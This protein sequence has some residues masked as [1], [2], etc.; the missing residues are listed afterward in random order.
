MVARRLIWSTLWGS[1]W[2]DLVR[3]GIGQQISAD[4]TGFVELLGSGG[5]DAE[6]LLKCGEQ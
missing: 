4:P 1:R 2:F 3:S 5:F 6:S